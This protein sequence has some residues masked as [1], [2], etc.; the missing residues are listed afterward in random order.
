MLH[1]LTVNAFD[2]VR[3]VS[4]GVL[5]LPAAVAAAA[6]WGRKSKSFCCAFY[7]YRRDTLP[8]IAPRRNV[9]AFALAHRILTVHNYASALSLLHNASQ[10]DSHTATLSCQTCV[11]HSTYPISSNISNNNNLQLFPTHQS[12]SISLVV[13]TI[14]ANSRKN[15]SVNSLRVHCYN[16]RVLQTMLKLKPQPEATSAQTARQ[17]SNNNDWRRQAIWLIYEIRLRLCGKCYANS[18]GSVEFEKEATVLAYLPIE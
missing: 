12:I 5:L 1:D 8:L 10:W 14:R 13:G 11:T 18:C 9:G 4:S 7:S 6:L 3:C 15:K 16:Y 2:F 17:A